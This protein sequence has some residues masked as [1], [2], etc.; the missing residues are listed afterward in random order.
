MESPPSGSNSNNRSLFQKFLDGA[1]NT[2][3]WRVEEFKEKGS[4]GF[5]SGKERGSATAGSSFKRAAMFA[6]F[7]T[8][9]KREHLL[10]SVG[11]NTRQAKAEAKGLGKIMLAAAPLIT[12][13]DAYHS[14]EQGD[15]P[16]QYFSGLVLPWMAG[17]SGWHVGKQIG[18]GTNRSA[19]NMHALNIKRKRRGAEQRGTSRDNRIKRSMLNARL[20]G[21]PFG[22]K[23]KFVSKGM[24]SLIM[25]VG[26]GITGGAITGGIATFLMAPVL[27]GATKGSSE[28]SE[29]Y[30]VMATR[31]VS[32]NFV[33]NE[34]TLTA[35]QRGIER[36]RDSKLSD[37]DTVLANEAMVMAGVL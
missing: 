11:L 35:A 18:V 33:Q 5:T 13:I 8:G 23:S 21:T 27:E 6:T 14:V 15:N 20:P 7:G 34:N 26:A 9:M 32:E 29:L 16:L 36:M 37:R 1:K 10:S 31:D 28:V 30:D 24:S 22:R 25:G 19:R 2:A 12:A 4:F 17:S 3:G